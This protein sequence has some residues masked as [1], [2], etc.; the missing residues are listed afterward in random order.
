M[1]AA[2][3]YVITVLCMGA[4]TVWARSGM[5]VCVPDPLPDPLPGWALGLRCSFVQASCLATA[6]ILSSALPAGSLPGQSCGSFCGVLCWCV[7]AC[8]QGA[9]EHGGVMC[10]NLCVD[11][12]GQAWEVA[13]E[14]CRRVCWV[15][16][17]GCWQRLG[18]G[19][20]VGW[21]VYSWV[22]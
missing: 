4:P 21:L 20:L 13:V 11:T 12:S 14:S 9:E 5:P 15:V 3:R 8:Q 19:W 7:N 2:G 17:P 1:L 18:V 10:L 22:C 6:T 16:C